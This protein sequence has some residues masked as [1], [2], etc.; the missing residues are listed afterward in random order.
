MKGITGENRAIL[1][2]KKGVFGE[3]EPKEHKGFFIVRSKVVLFMLRKGFLKIY[4][5]Q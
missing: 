3:K 1:G 4:F 5:C 2:A